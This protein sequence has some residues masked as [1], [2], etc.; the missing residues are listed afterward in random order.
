[1]LDWKCGMVKKNAKQ[2]GVND[3]RG[4]KCKQLFSKSTDNVKQIQN[5]TSEIFFL[6]FS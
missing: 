2:E 6:Q 1:M 4:V 3:G 5:F